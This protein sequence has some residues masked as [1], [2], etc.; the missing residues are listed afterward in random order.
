MS[1]SKESKSRGRWKSRARTVVRKHYIL[2]VLLCLA[3][4]FYGNEFGYVRTHGTDTYNFLTGQD[5]EGTGI[6]VRIDGKS[7]LD[8]AAEEL[9]GIDTAAVKARNAKHAERIIESGS[10]QLK[11]IRGGSRGMLS[12]VANMF[13]S[14]GITQAIADAGYSIFHSRSFIN[15]LMIIVSLLITMFIWVFLKNIYIAVLRR[16]F[17][18]ARIYD[19]VPFSH[20]LHFRVMGRWIK[21]SFS[22]LLCTLYRML[23]WLTIVGGVIKHYS[24]LLVPYIVAENPDIEPQEAILL[25]RRMMDGHKMEAFRLDLSFIGWHLLGIC[26]FGLAEAFWVVPYK[27]AAFSEYYAHMR[28]ISKKNGVEGTDILHDEYLFEKAGREI[29]EETYIESEVQELY[30]E[31]HEVKL[32]PVKKFFAKNFGLWIGNS[33]DKKAYDEVD[34]RRQQ[35]ISDRAAVNGEMYPQRLNPLWHEESFR[36]IR[37]A[38]SIR[39]YTIWS[40]IMIFFVFSFVGWGWEVGIHLIKDGVFVNRGVMH[41]PWLPVYGSGVAMIIV[42]LARWRRTPMTEAILTIL[43]CG[44]VE[45]MT[46]LYLEVA[47]GMRWWDYTGYFLNL[48]GRICGEGLMVFAIGGMA[49]VYLLVPLLDSLLSRFNPKIIAALS[50][51]LV[52]IF[53][54]DMVYSHNHPNIGEGIT[55]YDAYK[56]N[57]SV[58]EIIDY[59]YIPASTESRLLL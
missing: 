44:V 46:S 8:I 5:P 34:N 17:L 47:K 43:L 38:R 10:Q 22:M 41:G 31:T 56:Q 29:L 27:T 45:Y 12:P 19:K 48:D 20:V 40:V 28:R 42:V 51:V 1:G 49:A 23:W 13:S 16:M 2:L 18:E 50:I 6:V 26:T 4:V 25:S 32:S 57:E 58:I 36:V 52:I 53:S 21:A 35:I 55:D 14:G 54:Y 33:K 7:I 37:S 3:A 59:A 39:T 15:S 30:I 9:F 24:Y 11:Q